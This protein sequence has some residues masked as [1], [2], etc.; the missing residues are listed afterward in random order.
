MT[1]RRAV[2]VGGNPSAGAAKSTLVKGAC[3]GST[4]SGVGVGINAAGCIV[5]AGGIAEEGGGVPT[6]GAGHGTL[7]KSPAVWLTGGGIADRIDAA[8]LSTITGRVTKDV[9]GMP[10]GGAA[11]GTLIETAAVTLADNGIG[12]RIDAAGLA[13]VAGRSTGATL[14][15]IPTGTNASTQGQRRFRCREYFVGRRSLF[16]QSTATHQSNDHQRYMS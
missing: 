1:H 5:L 15:V 11:Q 10:T 7:V 12:E 2:G 6:I 16:L 14:R 4:G 8:G 9:R 3:I 13:T